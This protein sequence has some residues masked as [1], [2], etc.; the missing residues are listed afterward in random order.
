MSGEASRRGTAVIDPPGSVVIETK[1]HPPEVFS[2]YVSRPRL[3]QQLDAASVRP[4]TVV[5]APTG[6]GKSTLLAAWCKQAAPARRCAWLSLDESDN[7]PVVFWTYAL[8]ALRRLEPE[9]FAEQLRALQTPGVSLTRTVLP[10]VLNELWSLETGLVLVL[11]DYH[12]VTAPDCHESLE[13]LLRRMP[14]TL[15][16]VIGTRVDP[17]L[18]LAKLR[19]RAQMADVRMS[20]LR[21]TDAEAAAFLTEQLGLALTAVNVERIVE[22]TEGWP[23]G[24]YLG[25]LSLR[26]RADPG[27]FIAEFAGSNRHIVDYLASEVLQRLTDT[28]RMFLLRT[29]ILD[30][31]TATLCSAVVGEMDTTGLLAELELNNLFLIPLDGQRRWFRYHH[32][33][34]ELLQLRLASVEPELVPVLHHR[35]AAWFAGAGDVRSAMRH[36][37]L[38]RDFDMVAKLFIEHW[39]AFVAGGQLATLEG[40]LTLLPE[41]VF[42]TSPSLALAAAFVA[43]IV[44]RP[45]AEVERYIRLGETED[46]PDAPLPMGAHSVRSA[47][48]LLRAGWPHD[49]VGAALTAAE[50]AAAEETDPARGTY[51]LAR[52][53][54]GQLLFLAGRADEAT[55]PLTEVLNAPLAP[56]QPLLRIVARAI[57]AVVWVDRGELARAMELARRSMEE[58]TEARLPLVP[59]LWWVPVA[60]SRVLVQLGQLDEAERVLSAELERRIPEFRPLTRAVVLLAMAPVRFRLGHTDAGWTLLEEARV[61]LAGCA[62][63]GIV[64]AWLSEIERRVARQPRHAQPRPELSEGELRVMH[65][66]ASDLTRREIGHELYL[67][68]NTVRAH[69]R[70]IYTKLDVA[71]RQEAIARARALAL[72]I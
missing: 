64:P 25:A 3:I 5:T 55:A 43:S 46:D 48:A 54:L 68:V 2:E 7:D 28:E 12:Q 31:F 18:G 19:A 11:D 39:L 22:L 63:P 9:R 14:S 38:A 27:S 61:V 13:F 59:L 17:P 6:Y 33:F 26:E 69:M 20:D 34:Q 21:F 36:S 47:V 37:L 40:W 57:L 35:A 65:L 16:L 23:A 41:S 32:L 70:S 72:I 42:T 29:S 66:L 24:L 10:L 58:A 56:A 44:R 30:T 71:S 4:L 45:Q 67:S 50:T 53:S 52:C 1:L 51:I 15:R 49:N 62:D 60:L 8:H